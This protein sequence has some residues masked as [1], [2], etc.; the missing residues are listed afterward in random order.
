M[1]KLCLNGK[2]VIFVETVAQIKY[3]N[4]TDRNV[5]LNM[6]VLHFPELRVN[7]S[8][9]SCVCHVSVFGRCPG[10]LVAAMEYKHTFKLQDAIATAA[11]VDAAASSSFKR[12][13]FSLLKCYFSA[14]LLKH[15]SV[16]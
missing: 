1:I 3:G 4:I 16:I 13:Y 6:I 14:L 7:F 2:L 12:L 5:I 9:Q 10:C 11:H 8:V 15:A